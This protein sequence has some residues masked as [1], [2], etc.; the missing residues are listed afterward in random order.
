V[1]DID[2]QAAL[3]TLMLITALVASPA[4]A[5]HF[6]LPSLAIE[7]LAGLSWSDV[8]YGLGCSTANLDA[9]LSPSQRR[10]SA[11]PGGHQ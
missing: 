8:L 1:R 10:R 7:P 6:T 2:W 11:A 9:C 5:T 4:R 3:I